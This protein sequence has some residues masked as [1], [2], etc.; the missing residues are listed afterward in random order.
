MA[1]EQDQ[2]YARKYGQVMARAWADEDFKAELLANPTAVLRD[3]GLAI[4]D[5]L[6]VRLFENTESVVYLPML[7]KPSE[8]LSDEQLAQVSGGTTAGSAGTASSFFCVSSSLSSLASA[9][10]AGTAG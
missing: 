7:P 4:P 8:E 6:E 9:G 3:N 1:L 5:G 2:E 10:T